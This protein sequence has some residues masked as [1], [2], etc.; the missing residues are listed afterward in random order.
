MSLDHSG[1]LLSL[2]WFN[3]LGL[4]P[5]APHGRKQLRD[6]SVSFV[7]L[8]AI[9]SFGKTSYLIDYIYL[10]AALLPC[11]SP[12]LVAERSSFQG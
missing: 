1:L 8:I 11:V 6:L 4:E 5:S 2:L 3:P 12:A 9:V 10:A 7:K